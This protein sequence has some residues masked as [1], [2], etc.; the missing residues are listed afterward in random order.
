[1]DRSVHAALLATIAIALL[2]TTAEATKERLVYSF[3]GTSGWSPEASLIIGADG[4]LYGTTE[5]GG[6]ESC[7]CGVVFKV[8]PDGQETVLHSFNGDDGAYPIAEL[9]ADAAGNL[10]GTAYQGGTNFA[11]SVFKVTPAGKTK[12]IYNFAGGSDGARPDAGLVADETG[13]F[14][15]TTTRG[16]TNDSG[17]VFKITPAGEESVLYSFAGGSDGFEPIGTLLRDASGN[18]YGTAT[19]GGLDCDGTGFGCGVVFKLTPGGH[20]TVLYRFE[21]GDHGADPAAGLVMDEK[22]NL[23]GTTNNG[24]IACDDSGATCGT[25]FKLTPKGKEIPLHVFQGGS[26][27][28]FPRSRLLLLPDGNLYGTA[29]EGG[30]AGGEC[31]C[32][33]V[34]R[35]STKG[36]ERIL[37]TFGQSD[38]HDPFA[39]LVQDTAG[40]F[41]GTTAAGGD[42]DG[43]GAVFE[44]VP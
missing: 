32:G 42:A 21:G 36:K 17:T 38:G 26:D 20:E 15:G 2:T 37:H 27:G 19:N 18:L 44:L 12:I 8:T 29:A 34:F 3:T 5:E 11:G 31:G 30:A 13:N 25:V 6:T 43:F 7:G 10:Y 28:S 4:N 22:G 41:Y 35:M 14:Y 39:G 23:Y 9:I 40:N 33:I 24:G 16:G 1:M